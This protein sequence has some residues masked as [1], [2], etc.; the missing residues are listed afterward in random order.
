MGLLALFG[1]FTDRNDR[2]PYLFMYSTNEIPNPFRAEPSRIG[3]Y[4]GTF[5]NSLWSPPFL[6]SRIEC[7]R[8]KLARKNRTRVLMFS[9]NFLCILRWSEL[10]LGNALRRWFVKA[11]THKNLS[12][13]KVLFDWWILART[14]GVTSIL[15][16]CVETL[17]ATFASEATYAG[18]GYLLKLVDLNIVW[19]IVVFKSSKIWKP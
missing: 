7:L 13:R 3:H 1:P 10:P 16:T 11:G 19:G 12:V 6:G 14:A 2:F 5:E 17:T 9:W 15:M 8:H 18:Q 4:S